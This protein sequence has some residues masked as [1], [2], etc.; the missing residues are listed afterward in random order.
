MYME[1]LVVDSDAKG[2]IDLNLPLEQ[3]IRR[4]ASKKGKFY[5]KLR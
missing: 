4:V 5:H 1:K 3:N 2:M